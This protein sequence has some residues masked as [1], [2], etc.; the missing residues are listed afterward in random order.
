MPK[1]LAAISV[2][3]RY[4]YLL[5][6]SNLFFKISDHKGVPRSHRITEVAQGRSHFRCF[7]TICMFP[8]KSDIIDE[9]HTSES[10]SGG[11]NGHR[12]QGRRHERS[13]FTGPE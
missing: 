5:T 2:K 8:P 9:R 7:D 3:R 12:G 4:H 10:V 13:P 11:G 1:E 6:T